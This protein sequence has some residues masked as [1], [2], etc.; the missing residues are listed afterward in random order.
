L[1]LPSGSAIKET[2]SKPKHSPFSNYPVEGIE[3]PVPWKN[4]LIQNNSVHALP[5]GT[6]FAHVF[7][8]R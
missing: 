7:F 3:T 1:P 5:A 6:I 4:P 8:E 2:K